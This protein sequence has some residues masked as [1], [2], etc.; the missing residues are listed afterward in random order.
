MNPALLDE[1]VIVARPA[2]WTDEYSTVSRR[3]ALRGLLKAHRRDRARVRLADRRRKARA[4]RYAW[5]RA[6]IVWAREVMP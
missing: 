3:Q 5:L 6:A 2:P 1:L 4:A